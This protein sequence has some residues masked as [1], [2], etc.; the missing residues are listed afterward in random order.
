MSTCVVSGALRLCLSTLRRRRCSAVVLS[1]RRMRVSRAWR[2]RW[3]LTMPTRNL[4][5]QRFWREAYTPCRRT[6]SSTGPTWNLNTAL[7][8]GHTAVYGTWSPNALAVV[9]RLLHVGVFWFHFNLIYLFYFWH[10]YKSVWIRA[11]QIDVCN[12][13]LCSLRQGEDPVCTRQRGPA[14]FQRLAS[15]YWRGKGGG[16]QIPSDTPAPWAVSLSARPGRGDPRLPG[17]TS[18]RRDRLAPQGLLLTSSLWSQMHE[19]IT[20]G[21]VFDVLL[22]D[23]MGYPETDSPLWLFYT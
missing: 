9:S 10:H 17:Q 13:T 8:G 16:G 18:R 15:V 21:P 14:V 19:H 20:A 6:G 1:G 23:L 11:P 5:P 3:L 4:E 22:T 12:V 2:L 7:G